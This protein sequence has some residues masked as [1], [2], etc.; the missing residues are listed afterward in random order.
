MGDDRPNVYV[1]DGVVIYRASSLGNCIRSLVASRLE[2][3]PLPH[4]DF[5]LKAFDEGN[6]NEPV[7]LAELANRGYVLEH[8]GDGEQLET[9]IPIGDKIRIRCHPDGI[10]YA[11]LDAGSRRVVEVKA[12]ARSTW[13]KFHSKGLDE[14][15]YYKMQVSIEMH[16]TG[17]PCLFV[18][19]L[20]NP[21]RD[22]LCD[23]FVVTLIDKPP[24]PLNVIKAKVI[25]VESLAKKG[26]L[27][28]CDF[29]QYPCQF[30]HLHEDEEAGTGE[31][32]VDLEIDLLLTNYV[33]GQE[34]EKEAKALKAPASEQIKKI[35]ESRGVEKIERLKHVISTVSRANTSYD[36][37][38]MMD[39]WGREE[40]GKFITT[41][42]SQYVKVTEKN[43]KKDKE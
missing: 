26:E 18:V 13:D 12:L 23:Q 29:N 8:T 7:I 3:E 16:S 31:I 37:P 40:V 43:G 27:P 38:G 15:P 19:G 33:R 30:V 35:L 41:T 9:E 28:S 39:K 1:E 17:L 11:N 6:R 24:I 14:F 10:G 34:L 4:P 2:M 36:V 22:N 25:K 42:K 21:D 5:L 20:K 32:G